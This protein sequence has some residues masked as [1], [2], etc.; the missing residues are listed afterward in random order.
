MVLVVVCLR[1]RVLLHQRP[2]SRHQPEHSGCGLGRQ[3]AQC[4][5]VLVGFHLFEH[6][7]LFLTFSSARR[8]VIKNMFT[9]LLTQFQ[10]TF[11]FLTA[12]PCVHVS[13]SFSAMRLCVLVWVT[14][15]PGGCT[16]YCTQL[17][18]ISFDWSAESRDLVSG[19][20]TNC[21]IFMQLRF[22]SHGS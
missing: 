4:V 8:R 9:T 18:K 7:R 12:L 16:W 21:Q 11:I 14:L 2:P 13:V 20:V 15:T 10:Q 22:N 5:L 6:K 3:R 19:A 1:A 17:H